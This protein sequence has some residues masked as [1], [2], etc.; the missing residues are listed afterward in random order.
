MSSPRRRWVGSTAT[1]VTPAA[2]TT[3]PGTARAKLY[4]AAVATIWWASNTARLRSYSNVSRSCAL[5]SASIGE[6]KAAASVA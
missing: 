6:P 5:L 1:N 3:A 2:G 4:A